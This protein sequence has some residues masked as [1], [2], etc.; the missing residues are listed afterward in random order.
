MNITSNQTSDI[1]EEIFIDEI[2]L[3]GISPA[4]LLFF[5]LNV[6]TLIMLQT[7]HVQNSSMNKYIKVYT[8]VSA[9]I[10]LLIFLNTFSH[11]P[12]YIAYSHSYFSRFYTCNIMILAGNTLSF[13]AN[14][15][16]IVIMVERLSRFVI[17]FHSFRN[18]SPYESAITILWFSFLTNLGSYY[19]NRAKSDEKFHQDLQND[20]YTLSYCEKTNFG[21]KNS[22][23]IFFLISYTINIVMVIGIGLPLCFVS[24][25]YFKR[26]ARK[27]IL[28]I[29]YNNIIQRASTLYIH[30]REIF[31]MPIIRMNPN[32]RTFGSIL[33]Y[34]KQVIY[35]FNVN[36]TRMTIAFT[37]FSVLTSSISLVLNYYL[38]YL[39]YDNKMFVYVN[40]MNQIAQLI[41]HGSNFFLLILFNRNFR[42]A[43][44]H[45]LSKK[46]EALDK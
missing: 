31:E 18:P 38:V 9:L 25:I 2:Y 39:E 27:K 29:R 24:V 33:H 44:R 5:I 13:F 17:V 8:F 30:E 16:T 43:L 36:L 4:S 41:K 11:M 46:T 10:C 26:Y 40:M 28:Q 37:L 6:I 3:Y 20:F 35:E 14:I 21:L 19:F 7:N 32:P 15:I 34:T 23:R 12:K 45:C 22:G 1:L 42:K